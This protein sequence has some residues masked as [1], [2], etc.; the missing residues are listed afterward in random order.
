MML[1]TGPDK[2]M[3]AA[4]E[5]GFTVLEIL[6]V[7]L[8]IALAMAVS[9]PSFSRGSARLH[10]QACSRD[11]LNTFRYAREQAVTEQTQMIVTVDKDNQE[12]TLSN[13]LGDDPK[14]YTLPE[15]VRI[16]RIALG[17]D[18][19][20]DSTMTVRF[21]PNGGAD[22]AEVLLS[23]ESGAQLDVITDPLTGGARIESAQ[24]TN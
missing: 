23:L 18:E 4:K 21:L 13:T 19:V 24:G 22:S 20:L 15:D 9:Y 3:K 2:F 8:V 14:T 12:L 16:V 7:V 1:P 17:G 5:T 6:L 10:L 11:V